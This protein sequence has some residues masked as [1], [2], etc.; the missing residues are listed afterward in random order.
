MFL[1]YLFLYIHWGDVFS[2]RLF[3]S[4]LWGQTLYFKL[5]CSSMVWSICISVS[6][7]KD[8]LP[9]SRLWILCD[10]SIMISFPRALPSAS[11][12]ASVLGQTSCIIVHIRWHYFFSR[13]FFPH[14]SQAPHPFPFTGSHKICLNYCHQQLFLI[15]IHSTS[16]EGCFRGWGNAGEQMTRSPG[17]WVVCILV[18]EEDKRINELGHEA[19]T[20]QCDGEGGATAEEGNSGNLRRRS[21]DPPEK[22]K[23]VGGGRTV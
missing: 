6:P 12:S 13:T 23:G 17:S 21:R 5:Y 10:K 16:T 20:V 3:V 2:K 11:I 9:S 15:F 22:W 19:K 14:I 7:N 18:E 1:S 4:S 8:S